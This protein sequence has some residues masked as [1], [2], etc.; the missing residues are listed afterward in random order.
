MLESMKRDQAISE[1]AT[2]L[3]GEKYGDDVRTIA[4][5][6]SEEID[7]S[8]QNFS[9]ELCGGTHMSHTGKIGTFL[10][11]SEG[12]AAAGIRR[13]EAVTGR[14]AERIVRRKIKELRQVTKILSSSPDKSC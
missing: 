11:L 7:E 6:S 9:H 13:I 12:S 14:V 4:I 1:G 5:P 10:I 3:F 2:A 8:K